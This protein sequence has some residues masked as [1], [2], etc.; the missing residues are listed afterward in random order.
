MC[1]ISLRPTMTRL[2]IG[3]LLQ[4]LVSFRRSRYAFVLFRFDLSSSGVA[5]GA[6]LVLV[7]SQHAFTGIRF[8]GEHGSRP[9][10]ETDCVS[11]GL[12]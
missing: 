2:S 10:V 8:A 9:S 6:T 3:C 1:V 5:R 4:S 7:L 12:A 11:L